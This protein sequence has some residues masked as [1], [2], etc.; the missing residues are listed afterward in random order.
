MPF[1]RLVQAVD[2]WARL[3]PAVEVVAQVGGDMGYRPAAVRA[4]ES[5]SPA[6]YLEL[7]RA[8]E[9]MVAHAGMGS[10]L[11]ALECGKPMLLMP[12]RGVLQETRND[13]QVATLNWLRNK[14]GIYAAEDEQELQAALDRW[15]A[16][17]LAPP[18]VNGVHTEAMRS[19]IQALRAFIG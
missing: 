18:P 6:R 15:Q 13:H 1:R 5:V 7:V 8:C 2:Q 4:F 14:P 19:L 12:R 3:N 11:T 17:G 10:V 9:L 16:G